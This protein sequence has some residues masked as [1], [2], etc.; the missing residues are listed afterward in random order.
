MNPKQAPFPTDQQ[1]TPKPHL[2]SAIQTSNPHNILTTQSK[3]PAQ[4]PTIPAYPQ[5]TT[6]W[7]NIKHITGKTKVRP[8]RFLQIKA[9]R[10]ASLPQLWG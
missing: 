1:P 7:Q 5:P 10:P 8:T 3:Q 6:Q 4:R 9:H 2:T